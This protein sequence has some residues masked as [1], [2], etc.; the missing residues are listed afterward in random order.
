MYR[1]VEVDVDIDLADFDTE[2]L[3][4]ELRSRNLDDADMYDIKYVVQKLYE[5]KIVNR[6]EEFD[7]HL[8]TLFDT[9]LGRIL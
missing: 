4:S 3:L 6:N 9:I 8:A 2:D 7:R 1:T 5:S